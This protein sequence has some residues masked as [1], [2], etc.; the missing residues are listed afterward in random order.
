[1][2]AERWPEVTATFHRVLERPPQDR[3]AYLALACAED[4]WLR[5]EVETLLASYDHARDTSSFAGEALEAI[6]RG[7]LDALA[8]GQRVGRYEVEAPLGAGGMGAVYA[9]R[10][11]TLDRRVALKVLPGHLAA[12][13]LAMGRFQQEARLASSLNH[14]N[15]VTVHE[16]GQDDGVHFI[17][18]ELIEGHTL[19]A[20]LTPEGMAAEAALPLALQ[21]ASALAA[22]HE[23]GVVHRDVKPENVMVR[24]DGLVKV[25]DFGLAKPEPA[26]APSLATAPGLVMGTVSYMSPEQARG[27]EVDAR[28]DVWSLGVVLY[29]MLGGRAPFGGGS[30]ADVLVALLEREPPP[31]AGLSGTALAAVVSRCLAKDRAER[32][33][34]AGELLGALRALPAAADDRPRRPLRK[35]SARAW[36]LAAAGA[37]LAAVLGVT[38]TPRR[39]AP[40]P[41]PAAPALAM[42]QVTHRGNVLFAAAS[43]DGARLAF[44]IEESGQSSVWV[45]RLDGEQEQ[46][47]VPPAAA[48][49]RGLAFSPDGRF[50]YLAADF[51]SD[52]T[53][54]LYRVPVEGGPRE[55]VLA[56]VSSGV[57]FSPD[58]AR[59]AFVRR[60]S[61][62][63]NALLVAG[64]DGAGAR[65]LLTATA[66]DVLVEVAPAWSPDGRTIAATRIVA[67]PQFNSSHVVLAVDPDTGAARPLGA[68]SR[69]RWAGGPAWV[70]DGSGVL[71]PVAGITTTSGQIV[72]LPFPQ[73]PPVE[74]THDVNSYLAVAGTGDPA[75]FIALRRELISS[76]WAAEPG[77]A[78]AKVTRGDGK[79]YYGLGW[80]PDGRIVCSSDESG[81]WN[82]WALDPATRTAQRL[83]SGPAIDAAPDVSADGQQVV[84][85]STRGTGRNLWVMAAGGGLR[86][87]TFGGGEY[88][89]QVSPQGWVAYTSYDSSAASGW[90]VPLSGGTPARIGGGVLRDPTFSSDGRWIAGHTQAQPGAPWRIGVWAAEAGAPAR[91]LELPGAG[92]AWQV[93]RWVPGSDALSYIEAR[94]DV[95][96]LW[97]WAAGRAPRPLTRFDSGRIF[98]YAWSR[99]GRRL[100]LIRGVYNRDLVEVRTRAE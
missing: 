100:A 57:A 56:G 55:E 44:V 60:L 61:P 84:F 95:H 34:T 43:R 47:L 2:S 54:A 37:T 27:Q 11:A 22:A 74:V 14:P 97:S 24:P 62:T 83:T 88:N 86:Q 5:Q 35:A 46:P 75:R 18:T 79:Y 58:G 31:L 42:R 17:A 99:D 78:A 32:Y 30:T 20:R 36:I 13:A 41:A 4:A 50:V 89:P 19:R 76:V 68:P 82:V 71:V 7:P 96:N 80:T 39:A 64:S 9:A 51:E 21:I 1:V 38:Y 98:A 52:D 26:G 63:Q 40:P 48:E 67:D 45:R 15:I 23:A 94:D 72:R 91:L 8:P 10:D 53:F 29:E 66:P 90:R 92:A 16:I 6:A 73:G 12:D 69:W 93:V 87:L 28:S 81:S 65:A 3:A 77:G 70:A 59:V 49:Y 33:R 25:L 85:Q